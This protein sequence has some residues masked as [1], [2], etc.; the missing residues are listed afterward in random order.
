M[1]YLNVPRRS[2]HFCT[3]ITETHGR[4]AMDILRKCDKHWPER[5]GT[6]NLL[7]T[8]YFKIWS[9]NPKRFDPSGSD[10]G[11]GVLIHICGPST[12]LLQCCGFRINL[13]KYKIERTGF[14]FCLSKRPDSFLS[15]RFSDP[16]RQ[17]YKRSFD[18]LVKN[19]RQFV[20]LS[21]CNNVGTR[22]SWCMTRRR[23]STTYSGATQGAKRA[24]RA[25]SGNSRPLV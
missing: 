18:Y 20:W 19:A 21:H 14:F 7:G 13:L 22:T 23:R 25:G 8:K 24:R 5:V 15:K 3:S 4:T 1:D 10:S 12:V 17:W 6:W 9:R 16:K 11:L 2:S